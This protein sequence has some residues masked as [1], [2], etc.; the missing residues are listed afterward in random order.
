M[1]INEPEGSTP[2]YDIAAEPLPRF[3]SFWE[4]PI[5]WL[6]RLCVRSILN[7]GH[8]LTIYSYTPAALRD[9]GI[10]ADIRDSRE[11]LPESA[12][13]HFR[14]V[15]RYALFANIFR[16]EL[17]RQGKGIWV[18]LDCHFLEQLYPLSPYVFGL[19]VPGKLNNAVLGLPLGSPMADAYMAAMTAVPLKTPWA[20]FRRRLKRELEI[21]LGRPLP[22]PS[23]QTNI[24]PRALTY[25]AN[26]YGLMEHAFP[27]DAFYPVATNDAL[28]LI[29]RDDRVVQAALTQRTVL[30]HLWH[31]QL[32]KHGLLAE[33][34]PA[35]SYLGQACKKFGIRA[36]SVAVRGLGGDNTTPL[37]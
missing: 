8:H 23:K 22:H 31:G 21:L 27:Q 14:S 34:P 17:Q 2:E 25:F 3:A 35:S 15:G 32:K 5:T 12:I 16:V 11:V 9:S 29:A 26:K 28:T 19:I 37:P 4:G 33:L 7:A 24:G 30:V 6:E 20:T 1:R 36:A 10:E 13:E 18:D